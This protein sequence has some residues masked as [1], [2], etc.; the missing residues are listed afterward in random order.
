MRGVAHTSK[1]SNTTSVLGSRS[2][3]RTASPSPGS[4]PG[5]LPTDKLGK[6]CADDPLV[7]NTGAG[8][9]GYYDRGAL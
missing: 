4:T 1:H 7:P 3:S 8:P 9:Y 2:G 5:E 6:P